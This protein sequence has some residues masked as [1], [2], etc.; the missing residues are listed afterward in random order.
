MSDSSIKSAKKKGR[1]KAR[2]EAEKL[3]M[4]EL[5]KAQA[6]ASSDASTQVGGGYAG[7]GTGAFVSTLAARIDTRAL[8]HVHVCTQT[9]ETQSYSTL[10]A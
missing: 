6:K 1:K 4:R 5:R 8:T 7:D 10:T 9:L 2:Q 3:R